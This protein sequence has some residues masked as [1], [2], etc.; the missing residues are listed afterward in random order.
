[1][2]SV[3]T[4]PTELLRGLRKRFAWSDPVVAAWAVT[5]LAAFVSAELLDYDMLVNTMRILFYST[6]FELIVEIPDQKADTPNLEQLFVLVSGLGALGIGFTIEMA[7]VAAAGDMT[8]AQLLAMAAINSRIY[9][10]FSTLDIRLRDSLRGHDAVSHPYTTVGA[11]FAF[12]IPFLLKG[13]VYIAG[14]SHAPQV[15]SAD[16]YFAIVAIA[17]TSALVVYYL[18]NG[19]SWGHGDEGDERDAEPAESAD[20]DESESVG[21]NPVADHPVAPNSDTGD[22]DGED[23]ASDAG[24][25]DADSHDDADGSTGD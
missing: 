3:V 8:P 16:T 4:G 18:G 19:L 21:E 9:A 13:W 23:G 10:N 1:M 6:L 15:H 12:T 24:S 7:A 25:D 11:A 20:V 22:T 14:K 2:A 17:A 5:L